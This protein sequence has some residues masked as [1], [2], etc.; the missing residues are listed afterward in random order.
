MK[1]QNRAEEVFDLGV[2]EVPVLEYRYVRVGGCGMLARA[3]DLLLLQY[4][5]Y[6]SMLLKIE[7]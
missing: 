7:N 2:L 6:C 5:R 3:Q 1:R 4:L